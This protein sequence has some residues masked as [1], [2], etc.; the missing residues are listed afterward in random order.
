MSLTKLTLHEA[1]DRLAAGDLTS[2]ALVEALLERIDN[3][4]DKVGAFVA[5]DRDSVLA[6]ADAS[7]KRRAAGEALGR[8]DGLPIALKDNIVEKGEEARCSSS[9]LNGLKNV[10]DAEVV[11]RMRAAGCILFGRTNMDEFA[12]G[13][14]TETSQAG[15]TCNPW[16]LDRVPGGSSGGSA[17]G[18]RRC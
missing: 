18:S 15:K 5:L 17:A 2:R 14:S 8:Y 7:D 3:V 12:M 4:E 13:S 1:A 9:I 11:R 16:D 10:Y 6:A